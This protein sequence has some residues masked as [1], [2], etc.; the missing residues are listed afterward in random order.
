M[1]KMT[2]TQHQRRL[3]GNEDMVERQEE[4]EEL[5]VGTTRNKDKEFMSLESLPEVC[6]DA[7]HDE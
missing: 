6:R 4:Y 3:G 1:T 7:L 2:N 5:R